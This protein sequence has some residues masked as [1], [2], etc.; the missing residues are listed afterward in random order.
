MFRKLS[1]SFLLVTLL[2]L[3]A[4]PNLAFKDSPMDWVFAP[5]HTRGLVCP[6]RRYGCCTDLDAWRTGQPCTSQHATKNPNDCFRRRQWACCQGE[7]S[8]DRDFGQESGV[9]GVMG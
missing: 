3:T 6:S 8:D 7:V 2:V 9:V 5:H 1:K 4:I